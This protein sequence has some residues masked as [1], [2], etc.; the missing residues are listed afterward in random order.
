MTLFLTVVSVGGRLPSGPVGPDGP[1]PEPLSVHEGDGVLGLDL[2]REGDEAVA[3]RLE[4]LRIPHHPAVPI[5]GKRRRRDRNQ[6][7]GLGSI[8]RLVCG[9]G[10]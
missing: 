10:G 2:L 1:G 5:K 6:F 4:G 9:G 3:F 8:T 7:C